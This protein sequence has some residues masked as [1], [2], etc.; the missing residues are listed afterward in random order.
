MEASG[1]IMKDQQIEFNALSGSLSMMS[2]G[3]PESKPLLLEAHRR[4]STQRRPGLVSTHHLAASTSVHLNPILSNKMDS[5]KFESASRV[6][7]PPKL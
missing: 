7:A 3:R 4:N 6:R 1:N 5:G 2:K